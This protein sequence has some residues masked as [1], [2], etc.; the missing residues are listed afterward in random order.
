[1]N[2][3]L[4]IIVDNIVRQPAILLSLIAL[5]GL[6]LQKKSVND[7]I[8]GVLLT[9]IGVSILAFG[10]DVIIS[11]ILPLQNAFSSINNTENQIETIS[12]ID[13]LAEYGGSIGL[14]MLI[15]FSINVLIAKFTKIKHIFL[16]GHMLFWIPY[17]FTAVAV[18]HHLKG[19]YIVLFAGLLSAVYFI[20]MPAVLTPFVV[21]VTGDKSFT[22]GHPAG[23]LSLIAALVARWVGDKNKSTEDIVVPQALGFFKEI[24][25]AGTIMLFLV[26]IIVSTWLGRAS[27]VIDDTQMIVTF[28]FMNALKFGAGLTIM[29]TG[30]RIM[31]QQILP[32]FQGISSKLVP[33]SIPALDCPIIF[34]Y[35]PN[36]V[37]IGF[38]IAMVISTILII[39]V[40]TTGWLTFLVLP[41]VITSFFE[42]GT[43]AVLA[44]GQGGL[45]GAII[46]TIVASVVMVVL[47]VVSV[48]I[49]SKTI[50]NWI[51]IFGGNDFS[52]FGYLA[53][54]IAGVF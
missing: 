9:A 6:L 31:I 7:V 4:V 30:V 33:N 17:V 13:V 15:A 12:S 11:S 29:L 49:F 19:P 16:T 14:A 22:I 48:P 38:L 1:M 42:C 27:M 8:K 37:I 44:D 50:A 51:M 26:Y 40:N 20:V 2:D 45:R 34:N 53:H 39:I 25:I 43:A 46:G 32:A 18:E 21:A 24:A 54:L 5:L 28:S 47:L 3:L 36:A 23:F 35:R 41:L 52:L 10:T